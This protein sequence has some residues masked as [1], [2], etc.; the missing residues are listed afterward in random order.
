MAM[1][2]QLTK[3]LFAVFDMDFGADLGEATLWALGKLY[4]HGSSAPEIFF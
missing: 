3:R 2:E 4:P 1:S